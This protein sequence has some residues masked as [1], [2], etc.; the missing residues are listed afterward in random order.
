MDGFFIFEAG[1]ESERFLEH[2]EVRSLAERVELTRSST[3]PVVLFHAA[4]DEPI[5]RLCEL[6]EE[7][8]GRL[9]PARRYFPTGGL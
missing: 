3:Q 9:K 1:E 7:M 4:D 2:P 6:A 8:G 5:E